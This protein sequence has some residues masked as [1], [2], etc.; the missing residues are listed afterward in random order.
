MII[1]LYGK[2]LN[3]LT[4][5]AKRHNI[6]RIEAAQRA[7]AILA[8]ADKEKRNGNDLAIIKNN[9]NE[10]HVKLIARISGV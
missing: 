3:D 1:N 5:F 8:I 6:S 2:I 4:K 7:F 9:N 10:K